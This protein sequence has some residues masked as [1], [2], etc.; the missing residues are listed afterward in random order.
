[1]TE[2]EFEATIKSGEVKQIIAP[3]VEPL[4][5]EQTVAILQA[6]MRDYVPL[7]EKL[8]NEQTP[9]TP[10]STDKHW[11]RVAHLTSG[12]DSITIPDLDL[13]EDK[14]YHIIVNCKNATTAGEIRARLNNDSGAGL[15]Q[16]L[17]NKA[18]DYAAGGS[19]TQAPTDSFNST[20]WSLGEP[21]E[22]NICDMKLAYNGGAVMGH[23]QYAG[24]S[25]DTGDMASVNGTGYWNSG[26]N[27]TSVKFFRPDA[28]ACDW[29]VFVY[30]PDLT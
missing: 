11:I 25:P 10:V 3:A 26:D 14:E 28:N 8:R 23:W 2:A 21:M 19:P 6:Q 30:K 16:W 24:R 5:L 15:H 20:D 4:S 17:L 9:S 29:E 18:Y 12:T 1:M 13:S 22:F 7:L 27:I